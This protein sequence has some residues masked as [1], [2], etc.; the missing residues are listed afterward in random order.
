M[1]Y[2]MNQVD[3]NVELLPAIILEA[4]GEVISRSDVMDGGTLFVPA[5]NEAE[6]GDYLEA[7]VDS[8]TGTQIGRMTYDDSTIGKPLNFTLHSRAFAEL[9]PMATM[10]FLKKK[11][12]DQLPSS[13]MYYQL[14]D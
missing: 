5:L 14:V 4:K 9:G 1:A 13:I 12:G 2:E 11:N 3:V 7:Y 6:I 10:Y 8:R